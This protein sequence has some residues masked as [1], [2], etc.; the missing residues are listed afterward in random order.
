MN[1]LRTIAGLSVVAV[2]GAAS[3]ATISLT[4]VYVGSTKGSITLPPAAYA[5]GAPAGLSVLNFSD[6]ASHT[7]D[8]KHVFRVDMVFTGADAGEDFRTIAFDIAPSANAAKINRNGTS[9]FA[10]PITG[11]NAAFNQN[12]PNSAYTVSDGGFDG[13][14]VFVAQTDAANANLKQNGESGPMGLGFF[15]LKT[16]DSLA[17][18]VSVAMSNGANFS[19]FTGNNPDGEGTD[20]TTAAGV[21]NGVFNIPAAGGDI[22]EPASL[23]LAAIAGLGLIRRRRA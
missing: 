15:Y 18:S 13:N 22:P 4:P 5:P 12:N 20:V 8:W 17:S 1:L 21:T 16:N 11:S 19:Y 9:T 2:A 23:G 14:G 6:A 10:S 3:A 7:S